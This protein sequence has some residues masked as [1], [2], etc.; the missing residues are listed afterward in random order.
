MKINESPRQ[1]T[2]PALLCLS[3][4][5]IC[6]VTGTLSSPLPNTSFCPRLLQLPRLKQHSN[7]GWEHPSLDRVARFSN[8]QVTS[9]EHEWA[10]EEL[11][12]IK[13]FME[14]PRQAVF[15]IFCWGVVTLEGRKRGQ[16]HGALAVSQH[17]LG[18]KVAQY[19]GQACI[20]IYITWK[21]AGN[22]TY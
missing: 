9:Y 3:E 4:N 14:T 22:C 13:L 12:L 6:R 16:G 11:Y 5:H 19:P 17:L 10:G 15:S 18:S 8:A 20:Y 21:L 7:R 2:L 1:A